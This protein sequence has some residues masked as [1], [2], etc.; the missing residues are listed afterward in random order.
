MNEPLSARKSYFWHPK[1]YPP[2]AVAN[3]PR[4]ISAGDGLYVT[5]GEGNRLLDSTSGLWNVNLGHSVGAIK[6]AIAEQLDI[7]PYYSAFRGYTN[8][9]AEL[10]SRKLIEEWFG[11]DGMARVFFTSGGSDSTETALRLARQYWKIEK[12]SDRYKYIS[13]KKSYHGTHFGGDSISGGTSARRP[14][15]PLLPG[16]FHVAEPFL[17]RNAFDEDNPER[18]GQ[19]CARMLEEE[20]QFQGPDT[21]AAFIA[22]PVM[23]AGGLIVPP[24]NYWPLVREICDRYGVLFIADEV[25]TAFG[26]SGFE[27][28]SRG[29]NVKPDIMATAKAITNGYFPF[30]ATLVNQR[31]ADAFERGGDKAVGNIAHGYTYSGHPVGCAAAIATLDLTRE[32][33]VWENAKVRGEQLMTGL[34]K[35]FQRHS[36]VGDVRGKGLM[37]CIEFVEDRKSKKAVTAKV[38]SRILDGMIKKGVIIRIRENTFIISPPLVVEPEH[39]DQIID[40]LDFAIPQG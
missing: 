13:L 3:P 39:V 25:V 1:D 11:K 27:C 31:I 7:L 2:D 37:A 12:Q 35:L 23:G 38:M 20:I 17:Y 30:G 14:Y 10:L 40:A 28:G 22:E 26:R 32:L 33:R 16:C 29:W 5:D 24:P 18:L 6:R 15:E 9:P 19:R 34:K 4:M 8:Q 21:V 36:L